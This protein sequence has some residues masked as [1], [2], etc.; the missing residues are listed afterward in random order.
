[1]K[2]TDTWKV[3]YFTHVSNENKPYQCPHCDQGF[4][5]PAPLNKHI[6]KKHGKKEPKQETTQQQHQF[7]SLPQPQS[8]GQFAQ[9]QNFGMFKHESNL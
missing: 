9:Q 6:Q 2:R 8:F 7:G 4:V 5:Q 3:H 1:M